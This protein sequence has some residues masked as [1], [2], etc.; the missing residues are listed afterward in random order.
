[1]L[2]QDEINLIA[3]GYRHMVEP[4]YGKLETAAEVVRVLEVALEGARRE[5]RISRTWREDNQNAATVIAFLEPT[6]L[7]LKMRLGLEH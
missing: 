2:N 1:M 6:I 5:Q 7:N 3:T 4:G